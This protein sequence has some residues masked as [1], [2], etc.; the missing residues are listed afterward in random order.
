M[1][2]RRGWRGAVKPPTT[3]RGGREAEASLRLAGALLR[4]PGAARWGWGLWVPVRGGRF[5]SKDV[6][7]AP[8]PDSPR[9]I[10][11]LGDGDGE[12]LSPTGI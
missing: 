1:A 11:L 4:G 8:I 3:A 6:N 10:P 5:G 12:D 7:G 9:G 2:G